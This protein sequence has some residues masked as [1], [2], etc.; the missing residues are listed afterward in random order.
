LCLPKADYIINIYDS[1]LHGYHYCYAVF[2]KQFT[3]HTEAWSKF[4]DIKINGAI[5]LAK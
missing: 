4:I 1:Y 3:N 2:I 5:L